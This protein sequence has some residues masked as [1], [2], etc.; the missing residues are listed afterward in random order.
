MHVHVNRYIQN[1]ALFS[2]LHSSIVIDGLG[3]TKLVAE[4]PFEGMQK[5]YR[6]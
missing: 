6:Q 2:P 5:E 3:I 4:R 1:Y